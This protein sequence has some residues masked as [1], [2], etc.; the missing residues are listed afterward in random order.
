MQRISYIALSL[1]IATLVGCGGVDDAPATVTV[2]GEVTFDGKPLPT[3]EIIFRP[4]DG[5]GRVDAAAIKDGKYSLE[6]TLGGRAVTITALREVLGVVAQELETGE[7][8]GE[9]EQYIPEA[10]NDRTTLTADVTESGDNTFNFPLE[11]A[12][13]AE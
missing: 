9:V 4:A 10:Y 2:T 8:G 3:G 1:C 5:N 12:S 11:G 7:A 13:A 6:C